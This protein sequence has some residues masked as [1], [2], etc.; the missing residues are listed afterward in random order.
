M[1]RIALTPEIQD[2]FDHIPEYAVDDVPDLIREIIQAIGVLQYNPLMG[3][4]VSADMREF[5]IGRSARG[6]VRT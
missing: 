2:D 5:V 1:A 3:R 4:A 6:Y